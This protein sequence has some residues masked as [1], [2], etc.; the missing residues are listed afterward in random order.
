MGPDKCV[1]ILGTHVQNNPHK[2]E[3]RENL[4]GTPQPPPQPLNMRTT[5]RLGSLL[6]RIILLLPKKSL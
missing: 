2:N 5:R 1:A 4:V 6:R 3:E